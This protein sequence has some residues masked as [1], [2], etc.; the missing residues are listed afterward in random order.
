[1]YPP[2]PSAIYQFLL[3]MVS[4]SGLFILFYFFFL[5]TYHF[6]SSYSCV[7][8]PIGGNRDQEIAT[9]GGRYTRQ[10]IPR[11]ADGVG[12]H[13]DT[14]Y[15][16]AEAAHINGATLEKK[17]DDRLEDDKSERMLIRGCRKHCA[18]M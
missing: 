15:Y 3:P 10:G 12:L 11:K 18:T 14:Q 5:H 7:I 8:G 1:M 17:E 2:S 4:H 16:I 13:N 9:K 6:F